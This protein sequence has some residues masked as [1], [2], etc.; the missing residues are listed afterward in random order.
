MRHE[1][2]SAQHTNVETAQTLDQI[3][4]RANQ[5][6]ARAMGAARNA[7]E[8]ALAAGRA[9]LTAKEICPAGSWGKWLAENFQGSERTARAYLRLAMHWH[10]L[11]GD[12][13]RAADASRRQVERMMAGLSASDG[14][15]NRSKRLAAPNIA[16]EPNSARENPKATAES[17]SRP[18]AQ[19]LPAPATE[20][21]LAQ[22]AR[23]LAQAVGELERLAAADRSDDADYADH[24]LA[25]LRLL[26]DGL[27]SMRWF[28]D[29]QVGPGWR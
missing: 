29:W 17:T 28:H 13:L 5:A 24:L 11:G 19:V 9:L 25:R 6:H 8:H 10:H 16:A 20:T 4:E 21:G 15:A 18:A 1:V 14:R 26:H 22:V 12:R 7:L 27:S 3:A 2:S 23:L